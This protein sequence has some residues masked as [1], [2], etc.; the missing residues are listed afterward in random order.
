MDTKAIPDYNRGVEVLIELQ[1]QYPNNFRVE[2]LGAIDIYNLLVKG[3]LGQEND[4][5]SIE[6]VIEKQFYQLKI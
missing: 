3:V 2:A 1:E 6:V 5:D 4:T